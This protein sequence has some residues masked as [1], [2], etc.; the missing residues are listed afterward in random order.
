MERLKPLFAKV[1]DIQESQV[2]DGLTRKQFEPW[3]SFN[4]L[5]LISA[6]E[7]ELSISFTMDEVEKIRTFKELS[8][9]VMGK[10]GSR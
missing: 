2:N 4:H 1:L 9:L 5:M 10:L 3:D 7:K 6:L 8:D